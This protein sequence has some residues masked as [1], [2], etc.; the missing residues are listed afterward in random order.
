MLTD[1]INK[2]FDSGK[3]TSLILIDLKKAF[4]IIDHEI[5]LKKIGCI[6][7]L[8]K[9]IS[10]F[11]LYLLGRTFKVNIDKKF[12]DPGNLTCGVSQGLY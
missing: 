2:G 8:E 12:L 3:Y 11:E 6:G 1:K 7:F 10:W 4:D 9:V 5:L